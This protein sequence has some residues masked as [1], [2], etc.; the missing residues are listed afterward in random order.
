MKR[1][2]VTRFWAICMAFILA[3]MPV[4]PVSMW[5]N[6]TDVKAAGMEQE[7]LT[8]DETYVS[9]LEVKEVMDGQAPFDENDNDGNDSNS[10]NLRVRSYDTVKYSVEYSIET[11]NGV[12]SYKNGYIWFEVDLPYKEEQVYFDTGVM[13]WM[14]TADGYQ[15][16]ITKNQDGTQKLKCAKKLALA[17]NTATSIPGKGTVEFIVQ[18]RGMRRGDTLQPTFYA[19]MDYNK[20]VSENSV[21]PDHASVTANGGKE[22]VKAESPVITVTSAPSYNIQLRAVQDIAAYKERDW[23]FS[24]GN[25]LALNKE[26][27]TVKGRVVGFAITLQL[28][29]PKT[30]KGIKGIEYPKG[31]ITFDVDMSSKYDREGAADI[32]LDDKPIYTPLVWSYGPSSFGDSMDGRSMKGTY[33]STY[34]EAP[35]NSTG[36]TIETDG[37]LVNAD[38]CETCWNGGTWRA[39]QNG[40]KIT[41]TVSDYEINPNWFPTKNVSALNFEYAENKNI[42]CFSAGELFV[43][44]P[45]GEDNDYLATNY[46]PG[47]VE[48]Q[49]R[50][51]NM[52]M[53]SQSDVAVTTQAK[54]DDDLATKVIHL[55]MPGTYTNRILYAYAGADGIGY[56]EDVNNVANG[57]CYG[58]GED[59]STVGSKV[60][61]IWG[62]VSNG[63]SGDENRVEAGDF[64]LKFDDD[65]LEIDTSKEFATYDE[66]LTGNHTYYYA[67][68]QDGKG[69][70]DDD[71]MEAATI[72]SLRYY[73]TLAEA[74]QHGVCVGILWSFRCDHSENIHDDESYWY[75]HLNSQDMISK[76]YF[77]VKNDSNLIDKVFQTV[78]RATF[79]RA[80]ELT[81]LPTDQ[82]GNVDTSK[83]P[84]PYEVQKNGAV[85]PEPEAGNKN[86]NHDGYTK[87][88]YESG[89]YKSGHTA[90]SNG[91]ERGDSLYLIGY[92]ARI[93]KE[94][95]QRDEN[96]STG[97]AKSVYD[98]DAGQDVVDYK[99]TPYMNLSAD[100]TWPNPTTMTIVDTLPIGVKYIPD[101]A[102]MGATYLPAANGYGGTFDGGTVVDPVQGTVT[103]DGENHD[104]LTWTIPNVT[105]QY[106]QPSIFYKVRIDENVKNEMNFSNTV[107][108]STTEDTRPHTEQNGNLDKVGF[109]VVKLSNVSITKRAAKARADVN[110]ILEYDIIWSNNSNSDA[111]DEIMLDV[112]PVNGKDSSVFEGDYEIEELTVTSSDPNYE[113]YYTVDP[114]VFGT[115]ARAYDYDDIKN[116]NSNGIVWKKA[117]VNSN[118][119]DFGSDKG[120]VTAWA[121]L[122]SIPKANKVTVR[123]SLKTTGNKAGNVYHNRAGLDEI[124]VSAPVTIVGRRLSG[125]TWVDIDRDGVREDGEMLLPGVKVTLCDGSGNPVTDLKGNV[126]TMNTDSE[127]NYKFENLPAGNFTVKFEDGTTSLGEYALTVPD[128]GQNDYVD[129]DAK[130]TGNNPQIT[131]IEMPIDT[132]ITRETIYEVNY[133]D[134]GFYQSGNLKI[135]KSVETPEDGE[136]STEFEITLTLTPPGSYTFTELKDTL[137][138]SYPVTDNK[139]VFMLKDGK[140]VEFV[141]IPAGT[142]YTVKEKDSKLF[143]ETISY[144]NNEKEI[145]TLTDVVEVKNRR[146]N[147][148]LDGITWFDK[149]KN[150]QRETGE[151]RL[152]NVKV[153]LYDSQ[154]QIVKD[155]KENKDC[156]MFTNT[157][158]EYGFDNLPAGTFK[159]VFEDSTGVKISDYTLTVKDQG[160]DD[161]DSDA[162]VNDSGNPEISGIVMPTDDQI[163]NSPYRISH[164]DAGFYLAGKLRIAKTVKDGEAGE[165]NESFT[166]K[167]TLNHSTEQIIE[168]KSS[169]QNV[170]QL[171]NNNQVT[172]QLKAGEVIELIDLPVDTTYTVDENP[173]DLYYESIAYGNNTK[174]IKAN[175]T[176][177]VTVTNQRVNRLIAGTTWIDLDQDGKQEDGEPILPGVTVTVYDVQGYV[178]KDLKNGEECTAKTDSKGNYRFENLPAGTFKVV[179]TDGDVSLGDY[180]LTV[181]NAGTDDTKDSD[182]SENASQISITDIVMPTDEY[183]TDS[184]YEKLN[185]DAGFYQ[186]GKLKITKTVKDAQTGENHEFKVT[187]ALTFPGDLVL[188]QVKDTAGNAY[189]LSDGKF[190]ITVKNGTTLEFVDI[191]VG[192]TYVVTEENHVLYSEN[193]T[194]GNTAKKITALVTDEVSLL[195]QRVNR[196]LAGTTWIDKDQ[197]GE[198]DPDEPV[199]PGVTV[200]LYD[201][202]GNI[203]KD[204]VTG[205]PC[206][207]VTDENGN[208]RFENLPSGK[209]TVVFTDGDV[210]IGDY[211]LTVPEASGVATNVN[212]DAKYDGNDPKITGIDMPADKDI[213]DSPYEV[214]YQDAGFY[215][216]EKI[217]VNGK[218]TWVDNKDKAGKRPKEITIHLYADGVKVESKKVTA[219]DKWSWIFTDLP[220]DRYGKDITYTI[221]EAKVKGYKTKYDGYNVTNTYVPKDPDEP[222]DPQDPKDPTDP[223]EPS[224]PTP[225]TST[226]TVPKTGDGAPIGMWIFLMLIGLTG[227]FVVG[228]TIFSEKR[229]NK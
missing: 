227:M 52:S 96:D 165:E 13:N 2:R 93:N 143:Q 58:N 44:V 19:Y 95:L 73:P 125:T 216:V 141:D 37:A 224:K 212:S 56:R 47:T 200:T 10:H 185:L 151:E 217:A 153:T 198:R 221:K 8:G 41:F 174:T 175:V 191:P 36:K 126:C 168:V 109:S 6:T 130:L 194:Y 1:S 188:N 89:V 84:T 110:D 105:V 155:L 31:P 219:K 148:A 21:C 197:D 137:D 102:V 201:E 35:L 90:L 87:A 65:A 61:I 48:L 60:A 209:I 45:Y 213:K 164:L 20:S 77:K 210:S 173:G 132:R 117:I 154:G 28:Y 18:V 135:T 127:G 214:L 139:V 120:S 17:G 22:Y 59:I 202:N 189:A 98:L 92:V 57:A 32:E 43:V 121:V 88:S 81:G 196:V 136:E 215:L 123:N 157:S 205:K 12:D 3:V 129:S 124:T 222:K 99:L 160:T 55:S 146:V 118:K 11:Y 97:K 64:L 140:S 34:L 171:D 207:A 46:G 204:I 76:A 180:T 70:T 220:K 15:W 138:N 78:E 14:S 82:N 147:R 54:T 51:S 7:W 38:D 24:T 150:G 53:M 68:K 63:Q 183:I 66:C 170:Y 225:P 83:I 226:T 179:F 186:F 172:L 177:E 27:R 111:D 74:Q 163:Q 69:W 149:N 181:P 211:S 101:S 119:A 134:A 166:I 228:R 106:E 208:Y 128:S 104:T 178:V 71:D 67:V 30:N 91:W 107:T 133:L 40:K 50:D 190:E 145:T 100:V 62:G 113:V 167:V 29:N 4:S 206:V 72:E 122:G 103:I 152:P 229:K 223:Q 116:G 199:L 5:N 108:I 195:N 42:G 169:N 16:Q 142:T 115:K 192:T 94:I 39:E 75:Y 80:K 159:V 218:K 25:E 158:G 144:R 9:S 176:D 23:D 112:L 26:N 193:V 161:T 114:N 33:G 86:I 131:G 184:P 187:V 162:S 203:V 156:T 85:Q 79:W 49:L 182:A